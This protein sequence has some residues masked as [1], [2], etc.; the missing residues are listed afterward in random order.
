MNIA[1]KYLEFVLLLCFLGFIVYNKDYVI[2]QTS[3]IKKEY[4]ACPAPIK[5]SIG[6]VDKEFNLSTSQFRDAIQA[7]TQLWENNAQQKLFEEVPSGGMQINLVYDARQQETISLKKLDSKLKQ[8][9]STFINLEKNYTIEKNNFATLNNTYNEKLARYTQEATIYQQRVEKYKENPTEAEY[10]T[11]QAMLQ[12][13]KDGQTAL[14]SER[15]SLNA[16]IAKLNSTGT[17]LKNKTDSINKTV[18][19]YNT[20]APSLQQEFEQGLY[21]YDGVKRNIDIYQ[22]DSLES[23]SSVITH[24]FGHSM[25]LDHNNNPDSVMYYLH[26]NGDSQNITPE[27]VANIKRLC[28]NEFNNNVARYLEQIREYSLNIGKA[29]SSN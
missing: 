26:G 11:L 7:A 21:S 24:E 14:N 18:D 10:N 2:K 19:E 12:K 6:K 20:A 22:Y 28:G 5:Y 9:K 4:Y 27:D 16:Q 13:L 1:Y 23:L 25:S 15:D 17:M 29:M 3:G 8:E